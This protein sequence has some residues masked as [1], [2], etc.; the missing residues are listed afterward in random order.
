MDMERERMASV[1]F[2]S[3][4]VDLEYHCFLNAATLSLTSHIF[5]SII[6]EIPRSVSFVRTTM[7][8]IGLGAMVVTS[9][10]M[11]VV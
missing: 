11:Q 10:S 8:R 3:C 4:D 9:F 2:G 5:F 7:E 6:G 1:I